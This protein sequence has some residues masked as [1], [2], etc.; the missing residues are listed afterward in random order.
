MNSLSKWVLLIDLLLQLVI[1]RLVLAQQPTR[2]TLPVCATPDL[3][4]TRRKNLSSQANRAL[5]MKRATNGTQTPITYVPIRPHIFRRSNGTGGMT[6]A[7]LNNIMAITNSYYLTSNTGIQ[8]YF[9]GTAPDYIDDD[10]LYKSFT[11]YNESI[12]KDRDAPNAM[13]QYYVANFSQIG[14][15]GYAYFP[16]DNTLEST[17]SFILNEDDEN[18]LANRLL[19]HELGH[20]FGLFHTFGH[21]NSGTTELAARGEGANC[22]TAGDELCDTPA[23]PYGLPGASTK[24]VNGCLTYMGTATDAAGNLFTP[25][26]TNLMSYYYPCTHE[27]SPRQYERMQAGLALR[28]SHTA[29]SLDCP[30]TAV[31]APATLSASLAVAG[32]MLTW[33]DKADNEMGYFIER[34]TSATSGFMPIGG[35]GPNTTTF[36]DQKTDGFT[37]YYYRIRPSNATTNGLSPTNSIKTAACHPYFTSG[38]STNDGL[39]ELIVDGRT[40]SQNSGCLA[41]SYGSSTATSTTLTAGQS[42]SIAGTFLSPTYAEGVTVWADLNRNGRFEASEHELLYQTPAPSVGQFLGTIALPASLASGTMTIRVI[43][44]Y[45]AIPSDPCG[46]YVYGETEDYVISVVNP[47]PV[48]ADLRL[49]MRVANRSPM[50]D[51][52]VHYALTITN[53][54]P[55]TATGIGWQ[56]RLPAGMIFVDGDAGVVNSGTAVAG[57]GLV[58]ASGKSITIGY[59]LRPTRPG[60]Y[61]NAAQITA[62]QQADPDSSP[63]S[64]TG[65]GQD[66]MAWADMRVGTD[67]GATFVSPNPNQ[68]ALPPVASSQPALA[69]DKA[70]LSLALVVSTRTP[71]PGQKV[72]FT[73]SV[74]NSGGLDATNIVVRDTLRGLT[75]V[76][77]PPEGRVA[78]TG[79]NYVVLEL[80]IASIARNTT[81]T[82]V[83]MATPT[84]SGS[85]RNMAQIWSVDQPDPN[86]APGS[87]TPEANN[88]NGEDD[89]A[90]VD[91]RVVGAN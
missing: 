10:K 82:R 84:G 59:Q 51:Q 65:D 79:E 91:L 46:S 72:R 3:T 81:A 47:A 18:D 7:K 38:C 21:I 35:V 39:N 78:A 85:V 1:P 80:S 31:V 14:L 69:S 48:L 40:L 56:N 42:Y 66:D 50:P 89:V 73:L 53:D 32:V 36:T 45:D 9:C 75:T 70:D 34:S 87:V 24:I 5:T 43:V 33:Q 4:E 23:D 71:A 77:V 25:S 29:Y 20:N 12:A 41:G 61:I 67:T 28:E 49:S 62:S 16:N 54:G 11:A 6:M 8:F 22:L 13:N 83:F 76:T 64:G 19:P 88:A 27:F 17:R 52:S 55:S 26:L 63:N 44:R 37:T 57:N 90:W 58:L 15:G 60:T 30:A 2:G 86:S 68:T 74:K